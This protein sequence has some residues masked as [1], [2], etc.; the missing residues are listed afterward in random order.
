MKPGPLGLL[1]L[2]SIPLEM[3]AQ[4]PTDVVTYSNSDRGVTTFGT[5]GGTGTSMRVG[6]K[7]QDCRDN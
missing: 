1:L 7:Q 2:L 5:T 6:S 4:T 3:T